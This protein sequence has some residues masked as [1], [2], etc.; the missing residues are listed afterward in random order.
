MSILGL[1]CCVPL[2][3]G[4]TQVAEAIGNPANRGPLFLIVMMV[5]IIVIASMRRKRIVAVE[6]ES[7][8]I[9]ANSPALDARAF[10]E[11]SRYCPKY[12]KVRGVYWV[13]NQTRNVYYVRCSENVYNDCKAEL[14][15]FR[16]PTEI[17][18]SIR[19]GNVL[20]LHICPLEKSGLVSL[21]KLDKIVHD[22]LSRS[23]GEPRD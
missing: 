15:G 8:D 13:I 5:V 11:A 22:T 16:G 17:S 9:F 18:E 20:Q 4:L 21:S 6:Q 23:H 3:T 2:N 10:A 19:R 7:A 1:S 14:T 12:E